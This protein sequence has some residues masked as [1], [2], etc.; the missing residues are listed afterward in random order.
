MI[1]FLWHRF[2]TGR[3][4]KYLIISLSGLAGAMLLDL[5]EGMDRVVKKLEIVSGMS[6]HSVVHLLRLTEES[7]ELFSVTILF[8]AFL[9]YL[10]A[11]LK[12]KK[13]VI[14]E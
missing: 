10:A 4:R 7:M 1:W 12:G 5:A 13:I 3:L 14:S 9:R 11:T 6:E 2:G 8:F